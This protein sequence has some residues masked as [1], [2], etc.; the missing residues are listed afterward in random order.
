MFPLG[1]LH[2]IPQQIWKSACILKYK[3]FMWLV[4]YDR[5]NTRNL[6]NVKSFH[7]PSLSCVLCRKMTEVT[8]LHVMWD[9]TFALDCWEYI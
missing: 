9:Y 4:I 6:L 1:C 8:C 3:L 2:Q 7:I 5:S